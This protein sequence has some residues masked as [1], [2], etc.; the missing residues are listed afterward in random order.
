M[1]VLFVSPHPDDFI[2]MYGGALLKHKSKGDKIHI[3]I[4]S[5]CEH[6]DRNKG[7]RAETDSVIDTIV[8][9]TSIRMGLSNGELWV[10]EIRAKVRYILE[11]YRDDVGIDLVYSPWKDDIHQDHS[12]TFEEVARVFRYRSVLRG[13]YPHSC[14]GFAADYYV[15][16]TADEFVKKRE[17]IEHF[18]TQSGLRYM[19]YC[20]IGRVMTQAGDECGVEFAEKYKVWRLK[21]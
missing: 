9:D 8:P 3:L 7:I 12:A 11:M 14:P 15:E 18:K 6:L 2:L 19:D 5:E 20:Y 13:Y 4:L 17:I 16:L 10:P 21:E 1:N